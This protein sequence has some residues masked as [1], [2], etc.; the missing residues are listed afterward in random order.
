MPC[1]LN[2][3]CF[4]GKSGEDAQTSRSQTIPPEVC[5]ALW[6]TSDGCQTERDQ[7]QHQ[8]S[9]RATG[10]GTSESGENLGPRHIRRESQAKAHEAFVRAVDEMIQQ[11]KRSQGESSLNEFLDALKFHVKQQETSPTG[12]MD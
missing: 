2:C 10:A 9:I 8:E 6:A 12:E 7:L 5:R 11:S 1:I 3:T 4:A